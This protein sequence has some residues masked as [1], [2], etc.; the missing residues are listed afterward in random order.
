MKLRQLKYV[1]A[2]ADSGLNMSTAADR[3]YTSQPGVSKQVKLLEQEL[4]AQLF[5]RK[6]RSLTGIT[7]AGLEVISRARVIMREVESI[8]ARCAEYAL[9]EEPGEPV[10]FG[11]ANAG[12]APDAVLPP[13][14]P[15]RTANRHSHCSAPIDAG[16]GGYVR[17]ADARTSCRTR[18]IRRG[19]VE[20]S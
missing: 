7:A 8:R 13:A 20:N 2:I 9:D 17:I 5:V 15:R 1:L 10:L 16:R 12:S 14:S 11:R 6:G 18:A 3:V 4:G 19:R